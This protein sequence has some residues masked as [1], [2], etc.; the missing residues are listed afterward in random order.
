VSIAS[1]GTGHP[2]DPWG[3]EPQGIAQDGHQPRR[4]PLKRCRS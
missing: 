1:V 3:P 4:M 2:L